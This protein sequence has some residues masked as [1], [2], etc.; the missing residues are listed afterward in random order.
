MNRLLKRLVGLVF[1][2]MAFCATTPAS[3]LCTINT[4]FTVTTLTFNTGTYTPP[5]APSPQL[6]AM[7]VS[8]TYNSNGSSAQPLC[9]VAMSFNR[10]SAPVTMAR[11]GGGATMPYTI[12]SAPGAGNTLIFTGGGNP[13]S[14]QYV[15][16]SFN[17]AGTNL[18]NVNFTVVL[19][20]YFL[21]SPNSPQRQGNYT[22]S[23]DLR[24][25]N[26]AQASGT[27]TQVDAGTFTVTGTVA[28]ACTIGGVATPGADTA[29]IPVSTAGVVNTA[30]ISRSYLTVV[31]NSLT[32]VQA[33]S[34]SGAVKNAGTA[35]SGFTNL[36]NY[37]AAATFGGATSNVNTSTIATATGAEAGTIATT[38]STTPSGTLAVTIT[39]Q[40]SVLGLVSGAYSDTLRITLTPQ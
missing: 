21:V 11:T 38:A 20:I 39:P 9:T 33:T 26:V 23:L 22:D 4:N 31:C 8:G 3:A 36:I 1:A 7:S 34:Q 29:T 32:N 35:P 28:R 19:N 37:S 25:Y 24:F 5:T 12:Q 18:T 2:L 27:V 30:V 6:L 16:A 40:T 17:Q 14:T 10:A 15:S 13:T